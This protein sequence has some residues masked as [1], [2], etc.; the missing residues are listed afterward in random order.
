MT[1]LIL[2]I[3]RSAGDKDSRLEAAVYESFPGLKPVVLR[4]TADLTNRLRT[5]APYPSPEIFVLFVD[6]KACL[7]DIEKIDRYLEGKRL[8]LVL[9]DMD[10]DTRSIAYRLRPRFIG[11]IDGSLVDLCAV[12]ARMIATADPEKIRNHTTEGR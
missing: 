4:S 3:Q 2:F 7:H 6:T 12:I 10:K 5:P 1:H 8:I 9:A 11:H